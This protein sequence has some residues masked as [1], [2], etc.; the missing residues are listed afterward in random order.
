VINRGG[1]RSG[2]CD[3]NK[4]ALVCFG[5]SRR[6]MDGWMEGSRAIVALAIDLAR[7]FR[8]LFG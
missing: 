1:R 4:V 5:Q 3:C 8:M 2:G 7:N 6:S